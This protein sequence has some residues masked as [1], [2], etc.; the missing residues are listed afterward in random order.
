MKCSRFLTDNARE[1][2]GK[3]EKCFSLSK[4]LVSEPAPRGALPPRGLLRLGVDAAPD[5]VAHHLLRL[6]RGLP[7][8]LHLHLRLLPLRLV[9]EKG[10]KLH[11]LTGAL[12]FF[13]IFET[14]VSFIIWL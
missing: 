4:D 8:R 11:F 3:I 10:Q 12:N 14:L 2:S 9:R 1:T 13:G 5:A 6:L 7:H